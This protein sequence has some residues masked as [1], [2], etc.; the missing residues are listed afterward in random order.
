M[1]RDDMSEQTISGPGYAPGVF[2]IGDVLSSA[3]AVVGRQFPIY[4]IIYLISA[5]PSNAVL[6]FFGRPVPG[7]P[8]NVSAS[9]ALLGGSL[10]GLVLT[11]LAQSTVLYLAYSTLRSQPVS[12][13][14]AFGRALN[15]FFPMLGTVIC[16]GVVMILG[17]LLLIIPGLMVMIRYYVSPVACLIEER[18]PIDSLGRSATLTDGY[19]WP[20]LGIG[21]LVAAATFVITIPASTMLPGM[22]GQ[23]VATI[24]SMVL[25]T[26]FASVNSAIYVS[27]YHQLRLAKEGGE[28]DRLATVFD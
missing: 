24:V 14:D 5:I 26:A 13:G 3:F 9:L 7:Q 1:G 23:T 28:G 17:F 20:V 22:L 12:V 10:F 2:R 15:R 8:P 16:F 25:T 4:F 11:I 21:L 19:R 27:I 6:L 18:G